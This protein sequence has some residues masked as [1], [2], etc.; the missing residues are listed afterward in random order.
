MS[1]KGI[2]IDGHEIEFSHLDK[3][4]FSQKGIT[5]EDLISYY[6]DIAS[7][8]LPYYENRPLTT[9][10]CPEGIDKQCFI[11][12]KIPEYFPK[13]IDHYK[14]SKE[15][16]H[17]E[18]VLINNEATLIYLAN[19]DCIAFHLALSKIDKIQYPNYLIFDLDP[20]IDD[21]ILLK[22]VTK[23]V[24]DLIDLLDLKG[25][26]TTTG[27]RGFHI[28]V[29]LKR[30]FTFK[31]VR[32]FAKNFAAYLAQKYPEEITIEQRK[33]KRGKRIFLDF[34]RN[35][36]GMSMI[37]PYSIRALE[38][39]P[40]ATP[41]HWDELANKNLNAQTY[42]IKNIFKR[43]SQIEAPWKD[44]FRHQFSLESAQSKFMK[45]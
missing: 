32:D 11:Q 27:S 3:I 30:E 23:K 31:K 29:P 6:K 28:Y 10:R 2:K 33:E 13:W 15:G 20:S 18:Q 17:I 36:Y 16:G 5:K 25:F 19:Q 43:L 42:T 40:I 14:L 8:A 4:L 7:M 34:G 12:K 26:I 9:H 24:K 45:L 1:L 37:A 39:A 41:L 44:I 38:N 35:S 21:I 22:D